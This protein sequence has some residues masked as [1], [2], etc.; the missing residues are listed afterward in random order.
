METKKKK[1]KGFTL[2]EL[3]VVISVIS[4]LSSILVANARNTY[5]KSVIATLQES[6]HAIQIQVDIARI[7]YGLPVTGITGSGC[8]GCWYTGGVDLKQPYNSYFLD[9]AWSKLEFPTI[10]KDPWGRPFVI[11][12]KEDMTNCIIHDQVYTAGPDGVM[13]TSIFFHSPNPPGVISHGLGDDYLFSLTY[14]NCP[15]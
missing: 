13:D 6:A 3:L 2:I 4:L 14:F 10:P 7:T 15:N 11:Q 1:K 9:N 12:E 8:S 5:L